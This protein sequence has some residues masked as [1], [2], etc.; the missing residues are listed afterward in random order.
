MC[1]LAVKWS[2]WF[3][4]SSKICRANMLRSKHWLDGDNVAFF[5]IIRNWTLFI[6]VFQ[7]PHSIV[8]NLTCSFYLKSNKFQ[9]KMS[10]SESHLNFLPIRKFK[11]N[12]AFRCCVDINLPRKIHLYQLHPAEIRKQTTAYNWTLAKILA[13]HS[14]VTSNRRI[15]LLSGTWNCPYK[16]KNPRIRIWILFRFLFTEIFLHFLY[17]HFISWSLCVDRK[18]VRYSPFSSTN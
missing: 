18:L 16:N 17:S 12:S 5:W 7:L 4:D 15:L 13:R 2:G 14:I 3:C 11:L 6:F 9:F 10:S 8:S 1:S